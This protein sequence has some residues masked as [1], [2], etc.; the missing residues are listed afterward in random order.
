MKAVKKREQNLTAV[1]LVG[2]G[3]LVGLLLLSTVGRPGELAS[4]GT[5]GG[6]TGN[7]GQIQAGAAPVTS[8]VLTLP[9]PPPSCKKR[10][11]DHLVGASLEKI[12]QHVQRYVQRQLN[13]HGV[14]P[15]VRLVRP[16]TRVDVEALGLGCLGEFGAIEEPPFM[17]VILKGEFSFESMPGANLAVN[18]SPVNYVAYVFDLWSAEAVYLTSSKTG[19]TFRKALNDPTLPE[20]PSGY[21]VCPTP[22]PYTKTVHYGELAPPVA[23][24]TVAA[25]PTIPADWI[26]PTRT[27]VATVIRSATPTL[28]SIPPP[29]PTGET[30]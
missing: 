1:A 14:A 26:E 29:V 5:N 6:N 24:S 20:N 16:V 21:I 19:A 15:Q 17:L 3:L 2:L 9:L 10:C 4:D 8:T 28:V 7:P 13:T 22:L 25:E 11:D 12:G 18:D 30:R 27:A 23:T